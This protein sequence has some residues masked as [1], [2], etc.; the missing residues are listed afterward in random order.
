MAD[1]PLRSN[2]WW[3]RNL[4]KP[5]RAIRQGPRRS[6][7]GGSGRESSTGV[8]G[9]SRPHAA[10][11]KVAGAE[12]CPMARRT[13][14]RG[15]LPPSRPRHRVDAAQEGLVGH[16]KSVDAF[17]RAASFGKTWL[18]A[19]YLGPKPFSGT[20]QHP[21]ARGCHISPE[22]VITLFESEVDFSRFDR[23][24]AILQDV[25]RSNCMGGIST[26]GQATVSN[27]NGSHTLHHRP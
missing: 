27:A 21:F 3:W 9:G 7:Q 10:R 22:Q 15:V 18:D 25:P 8:A 13:T 11:G 24:L 19:S 17:L 16:A 1:H 2:R 14:T 6:P 26:V 4:R 23:V 20:L 5:R 12:A